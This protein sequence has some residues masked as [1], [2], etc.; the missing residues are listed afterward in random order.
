MP[1]RRPGS[2]R[3]RSRRGN[4]GRRHG[5][6]TGRSGD[7]CLRRHRRQ[8]GNRPAGA[9][10][11]WAAQ[12]YKKAGGGSSTSGAMKFDTKIAV[13]VAEDLAVWQKLNVTAFL[14][15]G[16]AFA[17]PELTGEPYRDADGI[18]YLALFRQPV[19]ALAGSQPA[20]ARARARAAARGLG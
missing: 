14:A 5:R 16:I 18:A 4:A 9:S 2:G 15:S 13:A 6:R 3:W 10:L 8:S 1:G 19:V 20:L 12:S 11:A 17:R 7:R